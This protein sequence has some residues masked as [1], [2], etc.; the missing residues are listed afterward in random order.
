MTGRRPG[1]R[2]AGGESLARA[3]AS[4]EEAG[5][6]RDVTE[7][8]VFYLI[9]TLLLVATLGLLEVVAARSVPVSP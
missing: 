5:E 4:H 2:R 1:I 9:V 7:M 3:R 8:R 6:E